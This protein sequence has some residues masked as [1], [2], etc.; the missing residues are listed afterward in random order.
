MTALIR[1]LLASVVVL[2]MALPV[3]ADDSNAAQG[4]QTASTDQQNTAAAD[5][6]STSS[7]GATATTTT[8]SDGSQTATATTAPAEPVNVNTAD[9]KAIKAGL[10]VTTTRAKAIVA[11]RTK[12]GPFKSVDDLSKVKGI[13]KSW[14]EKNRDKVTVG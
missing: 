5:T 10:K 8:N 6:S 7:N 13:T 9:A 1:T 12:N 3:Y 14:L 4:Q 11:Y 2:G